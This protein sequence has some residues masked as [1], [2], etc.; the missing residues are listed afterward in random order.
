MSRAYKV[1]VRASER[2]VIRA[3]DRVS[4]ELEILEILPAEQMAELIAME[5]EKR[6]F[7]RKAGQMVREDDS[8]VVTVD[9]RRGSVTVSSESAREIEV[10]GQREGRAWD[11]AGPNAVAVREQ[12]RHQLTEDLK[13]QETQQTTS[14][15][16]EVTDRLEKQLGDIRKELD[17][18]VNRAT[19]EAL[20]RKAAAMGQIK[21]I[22]E[23]VESGSLTIV[24]EV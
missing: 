21:E 6:G 14:L 8:V 5:L 23:D 7:E 18:A 12:L 24:V 22:S 10:A 3:H 16:S 13:K 4:T 2:R 1:S 19:A 11:D 9:P 20:K 15:Q 17:Q